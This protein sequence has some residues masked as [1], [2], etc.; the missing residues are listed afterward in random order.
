MYVPAKTP[1][2]TVTQLNKVIVDAVRR[3]DVK[4][5]LLKLGLYATGSSPEELGKIQKTD[6]ELWKPTI[7]AS[8]FKAVQ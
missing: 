5:R 4:E 2:E 8:G 7:E 1:T 3:P 6:S